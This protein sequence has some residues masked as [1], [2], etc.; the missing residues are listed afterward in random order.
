MAVVKAPTD[1]N[2]NKRP[3]KVVVCT[4]VESTGLLTNWT[5]DSFVIPQLGFALSLD[6][7]HR[8]PDIPEPRTA[9]GVLSRHIC[10]QC[11]PQEFLYTGAAHLRATGSKW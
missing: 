4:D 9:D 1:R 11:T 2:L 8:T 3:R 10:A 7:P 5:Q 6:P